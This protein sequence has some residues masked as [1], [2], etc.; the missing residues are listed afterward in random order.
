MVKTTTARVLLNLETLLRTHRG[1]GKCFPDKFKLLN[2]V[3]KRQKVLPNQIFAWSTTLEKS[4]RPHSI[5]HWH[6]C[7][8]TILVRASQAGSLVPLGGTIR[9]LFNTQ[10]YQSLES[11]INGLFFSFLSLVKG[12]FL[13]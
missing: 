10:P 12:D 1:G 9:H 3:R 5:V 8:K 11:A 4:P 6:F 7:Y 2:R 13:A